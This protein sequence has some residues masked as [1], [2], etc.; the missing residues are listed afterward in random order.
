MKDEKKDENK[1]KFKRY[2]TEIEV[3]FDFAYDLETRIKFEF[4]D[5]KKDESVSKL[6]QAISR[7]ISAEGLS[8]VSYKIVKPGDNLHM[9]LYLP[10]TKNPIHMEGEVKWCRIA[11]TSY[12]QYG[13][14]G[15][16]D[17]DIYQAGVRIVS[18]NNEPVPES[19]HFDKEY[20]VNWSV[21]LESVFGNYKMLMGEKFKKKP[22]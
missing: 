5:K 3:Y 9:E 16:K 18:V 7:N 6:Y 17:Q 20:E 14:K 2:N 4:I 12:E 11:P 15:K 1:R 10:S 22:E 21:V 8:L 13:L 19:V